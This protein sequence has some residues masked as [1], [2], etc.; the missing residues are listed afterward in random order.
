M[1]EDSS[2]KYQ[3]FVNDYQAGLDRKGSMQKI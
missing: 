3:A 2:M 1:A